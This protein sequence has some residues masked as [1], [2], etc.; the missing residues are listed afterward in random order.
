[1]FEKINKKQYVNNNI[2]VLLGLDGGPLS[3][4]TCAGAGNANPDVFYRKIK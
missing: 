1:M 4:A 3:A 2:G